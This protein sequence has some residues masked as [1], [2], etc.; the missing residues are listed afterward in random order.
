[1]GE[2]LDWILRLAGLIA[3]FYGV[4]KGIS[5]LF[6]RY[7]KIQK[8][9]YTVRKWLRFWK[10]GSK[11]VSAEIEGYINEDVYGRL[12]KN[13]FG[14]KVFDKG[15]KVKWEVKEKET[16]VPDVRKEG[17]KIVLVFSTDPDRVNNFVMALITYFE[18][19]FLVVERKFL[20]R[21]LF[22]AL[23]IILMED[24]LSKRGQEYLKFFRKRIL[25]SDMIK[26][27]EEVGHLLSRLRKIN[28]YG[29]V[30]AVIIPSIVVYCDKIIE[31]MTLP[32]NDFK[33]EWINFIEHLHE[34]IN[35]LHPETAPDDYED[36]DENRNRLPLYFRGKY[37][38]IGLG[39]IASRNRS[40]YSIHVKRA[41]D[42]FRS[43]CHFLF[44]TGLG[45]N[46]DGV[47]YVANRVQR[48]Y[49]G[50]RQVDG[51]SEIFIKPDRKTVKRTTALLETTD[52]RSLKGRFYSTY[53]KEL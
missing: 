22:D 9:Y 31:F 27:H 6:D 10:F 52:Y 25:S 23:K 53:S 19:A 40:G 18:K 4:I 48:D 43:G 15:V 49:E 24:I 32:P 44:I 29:F 21:N 28:K 5:E 16:E 12:N 42:C 37:L 2:V 46:E 34:V 17:E 39:L 35:V 20:E 50:C 51:F 45:Y 38:F 7:P 1:M 33:V 36:Y 11:E 13:S 41:I 8:A 14:Y 3:I 47:R 26:S 30:E